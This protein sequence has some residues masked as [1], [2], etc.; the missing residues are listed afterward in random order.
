MDQ[1]DDDI[2]DEDSI[3]NDKL[4]VL[5]CDL[6]TWPDIC[7]LLQQ[8][9]LC[10][11]S[12]EIGRIIRE[13]DDIV[14]A[15]SEDNDTSETNTIEYFLDEV[16]GEEERNVICTVLIPA[17]ASLA[18]NVY[19]SKP[20]IGVSKLG[21]GES[22]ARNIHPDFLA[23]ILA[24]SFLSTSG[25]TSLNLNILK[26][27]PQSPITHWKLRCYFHYFHKTLQVNTNANTSICKESDE[28]NTF[29]DLSQFSDVSLVPFNI[30]TENEDIDDGAL[31]LCFYENFSQG[32][33]PHSTPLNSDFGIKNLECIIPF[34]LVDDI[35]VNESIRVSLPSDEQ[36]SFCK[37]PELLRTERGLQD[38]LHSV[39]VSMKPCTAHKQNMK[40]ALRRP[41]V[42]AVTSADSESEDIKTKS[43]SKLSLS[44]SDSCINNQTDSELSYNLSEKEREGCMK[45]K[46]VRKTKI[47][48]KD[49]F[50]ERL[51]AA[52]ER[53]NTPDESDDPSANQSMMKPVQMR[54]SV[55]FSLERK[56][57]FLY[58]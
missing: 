42:P 13:L 22:E 34:L 39:F 36:L 52:L 40:S 9:Q 44:L 7:S 10:R 23:S 45:G 37:V 51:K 49:T 14:Y 28:K 3:D 47:R 30:T 29:E 26:L 6:P 31:R 18:L 53:G 27:D 21:A 20:Y 55:T 16:C 24:N 8:L 1:S 19:K 35:L 12:C 25:R 56:K 32:I 46:P 4:I 48:R 58:F 5:P 17:I 38:S 11:N 33:L 41:S 50:N 15:D 54:R 2:S 43:S 57:I